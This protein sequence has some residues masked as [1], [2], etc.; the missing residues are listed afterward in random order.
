MLD[1]MTLRSKLILSIPKS[2]TDQ[3]QQE[4]E[5]LIARTST[6]SVAMLE[7]YLARTD[8]HLSD[9]RFLFRS[10]CKTAK[11]EQLRETGSITYT[12]LRDS[13]KK[14]RSL[15][16]NPDNFS[17]HSLQAGGATA[18]ANNGVPNR[19]FKHHGRWKSDSVKD[20]YIEDSMEH[21]MYIFCWL[22]GSN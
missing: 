1:F 6:C 9:H 8:T 16:Y 15:G 13:F 17:L 4:D 7:T 2:K 14:L 10:I 5:L 19:L 20:G 21:R 22:R 11:L 12:C 3:L 18:A